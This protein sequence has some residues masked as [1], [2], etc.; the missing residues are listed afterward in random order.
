M[1][2]LWYTLWYRYDIWNVT[3]ACMLFYPSTLNIKNKGFYIQRFRKVAVHLRYGT[4]I[5]L[6]VWKMLFQCAVFSL[7][8]VVKQRLKCNTGKVCNCLIQFLLTTVLSIEE[9]VLLAEYVFWEGN[10]YIDIV[11]QQFAEKCPEAPCT[12]PHRKRTATFRTQIC[13]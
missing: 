3:S 6:S 9:R 1:L 12:V 7:Y 4:Y 5:W 2:D 8:S 13:L 11:Q 10:R